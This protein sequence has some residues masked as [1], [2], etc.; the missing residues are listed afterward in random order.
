MLLDV[1]EITNG[2][3]KAPG[4]LEAFNPALVTVERHWR[5]TTQVESSISYDGK[6]LGRFGDDAKIHPLGHWQPKMTEASAVN[7]AR[8]MFYQ[9]HRHLDLEPLNISSTRQMH[10]NLLA[11]ID[12]ALPDSTLS[13]RQVEHL[14]GLR[15]EAEAMVPPVSIG[16]LDI[17]EPH[18]DSPGL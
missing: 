4:P 8:R 2:V 10:K 12:T 5:S 15:E 17:Q 18:R 3:V 14:E 1:S 13:S 6:T 9:G 7:S 16:A 11:G